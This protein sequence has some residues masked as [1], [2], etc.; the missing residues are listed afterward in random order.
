MQSADHDVSR[1]LKSGIIREGEWLCCRAVGDVM[2]GTDI[3]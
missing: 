3:V 2:I 1:P